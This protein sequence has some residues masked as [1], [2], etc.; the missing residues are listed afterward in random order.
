MLFM[1]GFVI[2]GLI[3]F[4]QTPGRKY[5]EENQKKTQKVFLKNNLAHC[6][7]ILKRPVFYA[8]NVYKN[9][10]L[11]IFHIDYIMI[12]TMEKGRCGGFR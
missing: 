9:V 6:C 8:K 10:S 12:V 4:D 1:T 2:Q 7:L 5:N 11:F 3:C